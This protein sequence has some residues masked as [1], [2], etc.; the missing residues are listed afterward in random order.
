MREHTRKR[1]RH[2]NQDLLRSNL[3]ALEVVDYL[4]VEAR[5]EAK[6]L[7]SRELAECTQRLEQELLVPVARN[8]LEAAPLSKQVALEEMWTMEHRPDSRR[9]R[10]PVESHK[11]FRSPHPPLRPYDCED[12]DGHDEAAQQRSRKSRGW[13]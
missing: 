9:L 1:L 12:G 11:P 3:T 4:Q 5:V 7:W 8:C 10:Q 13:R 2:P 6:L